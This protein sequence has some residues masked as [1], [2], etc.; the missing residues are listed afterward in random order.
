MTYIFD[1]TGKLSLIMKVELYFFREMDIHI[2]VQGLRTHNEES[3]LEVMY[4]T[5]PCT[6]LT[7]RGLFSLQIVCVTTFVQA[8]MLKSV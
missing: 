8:H 3:I 6:A 4:Y 5:R 7:F 1:L 2:T